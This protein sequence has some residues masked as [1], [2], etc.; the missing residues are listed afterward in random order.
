MDRGAYVAASG[1]LLESRR[2]QVVA[3]NLANVNTVGYKAERLVS[4]KQEFSDTLASAITTDPRAEADHLR[5]PGVVDIETMTDFTPGPVEFTGNPL[6]VALRDPK[7]FFTIQGNDGPEFTRAGNFTLDSTGTLVTADGKPVLGEGGPIAIANGT[8]RISS[9][10]TV[11]V[12]GETV[13]ALRT[14]VI[15]DTSQLSRTEGTR[16]KLERPDDA[17]PEPADIVP[18]SVEMPNVNVVD[19]MVKMI[20]AQRSFE[21]YTKTMQTMNELNERALRSSRS[22]G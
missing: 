14:V 4:R 2:L 16:F 20:A 9:N 21:S 8:P 6:N 19:S 15:D 1:G 22:S 12:N 18:Q 17:R 7:Q 13:G 11:I 10:G 3:N 5:T